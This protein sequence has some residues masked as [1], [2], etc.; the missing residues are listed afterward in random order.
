ML[1]KHGR[2]TA[3]L[4]SEGRV[5][6]FIIGVGWGEWKPRTTFLESELQSER[7]TYERR[8]ANIQH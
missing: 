6:S 7:D 8:S 1:V 5:W 3:G 4:W 2:D